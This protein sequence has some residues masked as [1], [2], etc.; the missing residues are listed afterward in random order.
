MSL[1]TGE[2]LRWGLAGLFTAGLLVAAVSDHLAR[3]IPNWVVIA[4]IGLYLAAVA[5]RIAPTTLLSGLGAAAITFAVTYLLYHFDIFGAGDA[6]L[7][8]AAALFAGLSR[9]GTFALITV[10]IGGAIALAI[11]IFR[12]G[13]AIRAMTT[14]NRDS[15]EK[16]GIP[17]GVAIALGAI[18]TAWMT[19]GFYPIR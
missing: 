14:R 4:L 8:T 3:R 6:K 19:P 7:F 10:S 1:T 18:A 11:I 13:R 9:L 5:A 16:S 15:N 17:Y 2:I 12:P